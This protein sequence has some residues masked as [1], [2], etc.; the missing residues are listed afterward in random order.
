MAEFS[1]LIITE[2]GQELLAKMIA[3]TGTIE[4]TKICA[5]SAQY[6]EDQLTTLTAID[7]IR[8]TNLVSKVIRTNNTAVK[9]DTAYTNEDLTEGY[10]MRTLGLYAKEADAAEEVLYAVTVETSGNCYIPAYNGVT[11]TGAYLQFVTTVGNAENVSLE[12]DPGAY[13]TVGDIRTIETKLSKIQDYVGNSDTEEGLEFAEG[14][15]AD[16][17]VDAVNQVFQVGNEKKARLVENLVAVGVQAST[18]DTWEQLLDK[19]LAVTDTSTD[20]VTANVLLDGYT[21]HDSNG[22]LITGVMVDNAG[23]TVDAGNTTQDSTYAYLSIPQD[24]YYD[25]G[26]KVRTANSNI[27]IPKSVSISVSCEYR[28]HGSGGDH[29]ICALR[30][31]ANGAL[32]G[33]SD[34]RM[35][36]SGV[37]T[38]YAASAGCSGTWTG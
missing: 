7:E 20:T 16:N 37:P 14:L 13:A 35:L 22:D 25:Q 21:A 33:Q 4:F 11:I 26:S 9:I 30:I 18:S 23:V 3:Q 31:Y 29:A 1:K 24:G 2:S 12:V 36:N 32:I 6:L 34:T 17:L 10:Y 5:S 27:N 28:H 38:G 8:Q 15:E 19:V